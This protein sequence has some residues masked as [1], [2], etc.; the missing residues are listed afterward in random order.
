MK[1]VKYDCLPI[2]RERAIQSAYANH[3][4]SIFQCYSLKYEFSCDGRRRRVCHHKH[5]PDS[6]S[7]LK[8]QNIHIHTKRQSY[9]TPLCIFIYLNFFSSIFNSFLA[10]AKKIRKYF[11]KWKIHIPDLFSIVSLVWLLEKFIL[12]DSIFN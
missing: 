9:F 12:Q 3:I 7:R 5:Y 6:Y 11:Y 4:F 2:R 10:F 8:E 1:H